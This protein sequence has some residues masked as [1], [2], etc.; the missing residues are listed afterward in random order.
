MASDA[1]ELLNNMI[2]RMSKLPENPEGMYREIGV[3]L[4]SEILKTFKQGGRPVAWPVSARARKQGGQTMLNTGRL[5]KEESTPQISADGITFG[6]ILPYAAIHHFGFDGMQ[7]VKAFKRRVRSRDLV[8]KVGRTSERTGKHYT[9]SVV[10]EKGYAEV[11]AF[12]RH[13]RMPMRRAIMLQ[14]E[15]VPVIGEIILRAMTGAAS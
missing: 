14:D 9:T 15:N 8:A 6:S 13:M 10:S 3:Y 4:G 1:F 12:S 2:E 5:A 7:E 11:K